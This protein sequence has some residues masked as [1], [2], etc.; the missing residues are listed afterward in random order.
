MEFGDTPGGNTLFKRQAT[1]L[2][3]TAAIEYMPKHLWTAK[4]ARFVA[5]CI[6]GGLLCS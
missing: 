2:E 6:D 3:A 4:V 1:K 5:Y